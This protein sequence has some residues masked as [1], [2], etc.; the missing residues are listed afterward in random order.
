MHPLVLQWFPRW[1]EQRILR[2]ATAGK[3]RTERS[4]RMRLRLVLCWL[5]VLGRWSRMLMENRWLAN[6]SLELIPGLTKFHLSKRSAKI[7]SRL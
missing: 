1:R 3:G 4:L 7:G 5:T 2:Q 6:G